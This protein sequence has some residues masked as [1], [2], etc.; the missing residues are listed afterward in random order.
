M[1]ENTGSN[2][3]IFILM[4]AG[5]WWWNNHNTTWTGFYY[6][7]AGNLYVYKKSPELKTIDD[8]RNWVDNMADTYN[9][10]GADDDYECGKNCKLA[11]YSTD[12]YEC[13]TTE[14]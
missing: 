3:G 4:V 14:E 13:E 6:P 9:P 7:D 1:D 2:I 8:C 12:F 5:I 11:E 10:Y